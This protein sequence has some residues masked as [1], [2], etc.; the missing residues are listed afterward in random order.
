MRV[1]RDACFPNV[2]TPEVY[3]E[4]R[5]GQWAAVKK[6]PGDEVGRDDMNAHY[7]IYR[8]V[9]DHPN[10]EK[11][12]ARP[13]R[14][15]DQWWHIPMEWI[16][17][18]KLHTV[19]F[20]PRSTQMTPH[21]MSRIITGMC[22][23]LLFLHNNDITHQDINP[24]N[25]MVEKLDGNVHAVLI[26][27]FNHDG[28]EAIKKQTNKAYAAPETQ[29]NPFGRGEK[30]SDVWALGKV[31]YELLTGYEKPVTETDSENVLYDLKGYVYREVV[32][33]MVESNVMHRPTMESIIDYIREAEYK[34]Q[35][36]HSLSGPS[37]P[38]SNPFNALQSFD[39]HLQMQMNESI[40]HDLPPG[41]R[42]PDPLPTNSTLTLNYHRYDRIG[43][44]IEYKG[45]LRTTVD[46]RV[47]D[48]WWTVCKPNDVED[49]DRWCLE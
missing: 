2:K 18:E 32:A 22:E 39:H 44:R 6:I 23:G 1:S 45:E 43:R 31:I 8:D 49:E 11:I 35:S 42:L 48:V 17:G 15:W 9:V 14:Q 20:H 10:V 5:D 13:L 12:V 26:S 29:N 25:V 4:V 30:Y 40:R 33:A 47:R 41:F 7:E 27:V 36:T 19:M 24:K 3:R 16:S 28:L 37:V 38:L 46:R 34:V 21:I